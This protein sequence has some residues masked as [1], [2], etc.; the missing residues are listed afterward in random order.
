ML[1]QCPVEI[2][3]SNFWLLTDKTVEN[4]SSGNKGVCAYKK[5]K[6]LLTR[7]AQTPIFPLEKVSCS[8]V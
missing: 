6:I 7:K 1:K 2:K 3:G 5:T 4:M 8:F